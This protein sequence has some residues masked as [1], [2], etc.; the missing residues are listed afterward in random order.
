[1]AV[2]RRWYRPRNVVLAVIGVLAGV[3][4][5]AAVEV[6]KVQTAAPDVAVDYRA[7]F[8]RLACRALNL[9]EAA[10]DRAW[11]LLRELVET[12]DRTLDELED[13]IASEGIERRS[14]WDGGAIDFDYVLL[15][16]SLP[17]GV[18][19]ERRAIEALRAQGVLDQ[20]A[21]FAA[22]GTGING[23]PSSGMIIME[24]L[25]LGGARRLAR[26]RAAS[27]RIALSEGDLEEVVAAFDQQLAMAE[28][29]SC[30][31]G[32]INAL[33]GMSIAGSALD[34]LAGEL[35]ETEFDEATCRRLTDVLERRRLAP[36]DLVVAG[37]R[38]AFLDATQWMFSD[39]GAGDGF[40][41]PDAV[42]EGIPAGP[43]FVRAAL[44]RFYLASRAECVEVYERFVRECLREAELPQ[45]MRWQGL[46]RPDEFLGGL[47]RRFVPVSLMLGALDKA[48]RNYSVVRLRWDAA[49]IMLALEAHVARHGRY[50]EALED[51]VP[52]FL[53]RVPEDPFAGVA[54]GYGTVEGDSD[55]R[56]YLLYSCGVDRADDGGR[57]QDGDPWIALHTSGFDLV[58]NRTRG[59][60]P[61]GNSAERVPERVP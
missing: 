4:V 15:G 3:L 8:S 31:V 46:F 37:E 61:E 51:L 9:E 45:A 26:G 13:R 28:T 40:M 14:E 43:G 32:L 30:Q 60:R 7:E 25:E 59:T 1:M 47:G 39:D 44:S 18:D 29:I 54:L 53:P 33:V 49:R 35:I 12:S 55:G 50:P 41:L 5:W 16:P 34:E 38:I 48:L 6:R 17:A 57:L 10:A 52:S 24:S 20:L 27:M 23:R 58:L 36:V 19:R 22:G 21:R 56:R 2:S 42:T 11:A